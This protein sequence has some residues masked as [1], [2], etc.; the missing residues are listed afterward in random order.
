MVGNEIMVV[1]H[2]EIHAGG[3]LL[4]SESYLSNNRM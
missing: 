4:Y 1:I 2:D 3:D